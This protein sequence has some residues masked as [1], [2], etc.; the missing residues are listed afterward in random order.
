LARTRKP[1]EPTVYEGGLVPGNI[2]Q[3]TSPYNFQGSEVAVVLDKQK[4]CKDGIPV[5]LA[6]EDSP[7]RYLCLMAYHGDTVKKL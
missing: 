3:C 5:M 2:V 7:I 1:V 6:D 4:W